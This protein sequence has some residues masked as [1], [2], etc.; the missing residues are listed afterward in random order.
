MWGLILAPTICPADEPI[1]DDPAEQLNSRAQRE[2]ATSH[3]TTQDHNP[4][5]T[6]D[7]ATKPPESE[8]MPDASQA[9][10]VQSL[11]EAA[12]TASAAADAAGRRGDNAMYEKLTAYKRDY[13]RLADVARNQP[14]P[15]SI[16]PLEAGRRGCLYAVRRAEQRLNTGQGI[17][18]VPLQTVVW[19]KVKPTELKPDGSILCDV[20]DNTG[21][22]RLFR[23]R[24]F[25]AD[26]LRVGNTVQLINA[27][28][29]CTAVNARNDGTIYHLRPIPA[30][31]LAQ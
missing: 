5:G 28:F 18:T 9:T 25:G 16:Y 4:D 3:P 13:T 7:N 26:N 30:T 12:R 8:F 2:R 10:V 31:E 6:A 23:A 1:F 17:V 29:E 20:L 19:F 11:E 24:F 22:T 15:P 21:G 27:P 14:L